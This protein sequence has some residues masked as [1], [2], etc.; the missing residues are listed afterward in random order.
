MGLLETGSLTTRSIGCGLITVASEAF[1]GWFT[2][3]GLITEASGAFGDCMVPKPTGK[4]RGCGL[5][6]LTE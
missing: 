3:C 6:V 2:G 5:E 4:C 1:G